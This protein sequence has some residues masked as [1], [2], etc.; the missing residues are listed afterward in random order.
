MWWALVK[1]WL[2]FWASGGSISVLT[3]RRMLLATAAV[4]TRDAGMPTTMTS[5]IRN[6]AAPADP[7]QPENLRFLCR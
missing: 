3:S 4:T 5:R 7:G 1:G 2:G 6:S